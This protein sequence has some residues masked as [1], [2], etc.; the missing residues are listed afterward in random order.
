MSGD[1]RA[2]F[3]RVA[4]VNRAETAMR[5]RAGSLTLAES[6]LVKTFRNLFLVSREET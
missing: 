3:G 2:A 5:P 6:S 1:S 4:I